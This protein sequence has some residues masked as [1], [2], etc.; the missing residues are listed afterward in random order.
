MVYGDGYGSDSQRKWRIQE[1]FAS[2]SYWYHSSAIRYVFL[3]H[4][5]C[6]SHSLHQL[7]VDYK[8]DLLDYNAFTTC[9]LM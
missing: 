4:R 9:N 1:I 2:H 3:E 6:S 5:K 7:E 8:T